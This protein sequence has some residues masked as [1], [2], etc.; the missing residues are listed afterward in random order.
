MKQTYNN[1][2]LWQLQLAGW[3]ILLAIWYLVTNF[4][5][6]NNHVMPTPQKTWHSFLEMK[7]D[8]N[9]M[10]NIFFSLRINLF[11]YL[12]CVVAALLVGF[13]IGLSPKV[14]KMFSQ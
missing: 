3:I 7:S 8:D 12:K 11:G 9:L 1:K 6:I 14:R 13:A 10:S 2:Y 5:L 4:G